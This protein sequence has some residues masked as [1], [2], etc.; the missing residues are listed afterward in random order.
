MS[1][2]KIT[3]KITGEAEAVRAQLLAEAEA[4]R[5]GILS[6]AEK[7]AADLIAA[8]EARGLSEKEKMI[9]RRKSVAD[10]DCRKLIL[11]KKQELISQCFE[12]AVDAMVSMDET[13]YLKLLTALG[14]KTGRKEGLLIFNK[15]EKERIGQKLADALN[16]AVD[17]GAFSVA[18]ETRN[19]RGG[20]LLQSGKVYINNS[21]EALVEEHRDGL[22]AD[23]YAVLFP[24]T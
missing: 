5:D 12:K 1:L 18:E 4:E 20:Y 19:L 14:V 17:G 6:R 24:E 8:E 2:E 7:E 15:T 22:R 13:A 21:M 3:S 10:I 11:Q 23:V 9:S 16:A